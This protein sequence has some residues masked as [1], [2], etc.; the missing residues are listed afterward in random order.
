MKTRAII[1]SAA[2]IQRNQRRWTLCG[3]CICFHRRGPHVCNVEKSRR[4]GTR[5][6]DIANGTAHPGLRVWHT[7]RI[8]LSGDATAEIIARLYRKAGVI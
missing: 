6:H 4:R 8:W 1:R 7:R 3:K 5:L 2:R